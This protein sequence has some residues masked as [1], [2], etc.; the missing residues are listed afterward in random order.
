MTIVFCL[1]RA[2][3]VTTTL[4][5]RTTSY[6]SVETE[7]IPWQSALD[8]LHYYYLMLDQTDVYEPLQVQKQVCVSD[9]DELS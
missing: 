9:I 6:L 5:L 2:Q 3:K 7:Y 1:C 8:N 4:A